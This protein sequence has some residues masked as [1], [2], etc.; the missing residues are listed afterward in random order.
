MGGGGGGGAICFVI[1]HICNTDLTE[2]GEK[3][4]LPKNSC[5]TSKNT[6]STPKITP[7]DSNDLQF[8][9]VYTCLSQNVFSLPGQP[10]PKDELF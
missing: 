8:P 5:S 2:L 4:A 7:N 9:N 3:Q 1:D 10:T 6:V